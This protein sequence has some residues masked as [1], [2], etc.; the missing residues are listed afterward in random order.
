[1]SVRHVEKQKQKRGQS[2]GGQGGGQQDFKHEGESVNTEMR[3]SKNRIE[4]R[5]GDTVVGYYDK[6]SATWCFIGKVKLGTES[7]SHPVYG[8]NGGLGMTSDPSGNDAVLI[9]APKP[10]PPTSLDTKP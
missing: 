7:A 9:N 10:G 3:V 8:V 6:S 4:F 1:V 5:S 2:G